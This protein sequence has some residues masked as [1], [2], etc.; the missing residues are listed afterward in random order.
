MVSDMLCSASTYAGSIP[1]IYVCKHVRVRA[2]V[3]VQ[4]VWGRNHSLGR[5]DN[6][7]DVEVGLRYGVRLEHI[8]GEAHL[9]VRTRQHMDRT[10]QHM[11]I[12]ETH[13]H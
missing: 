5:R 2:S 6:H 4:L 13:P 7:V 9:Y 11:D 12:R 10:S 1:Y 3:C 8:G